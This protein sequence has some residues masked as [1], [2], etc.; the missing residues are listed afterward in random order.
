[1]A[2]ETC[3]IHM[4][5]SII[6][7]ETLAHRLGLIPIRWVCMYYCVLTFWCEFVALSQASIS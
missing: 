2:I 5:T 4:N 7:D 6:P 1:M 3:Y